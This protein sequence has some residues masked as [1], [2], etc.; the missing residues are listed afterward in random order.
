MIANLP[1]PAS[2]ESS[3][4]TL[5]LKHGEERRLAAGHLWVFSNEVDTDSTPLTAFSPG[6]PVQLQSDRDRFLGFAYVNPHSLICA[7]IVGRDPKYPLDKSLIVHR[8]KVALSLRRR[9]FSQPAYRL[10]YGESDGLPGLV[11]DRYG[12]VLVGQIGTAGMERLKPEIEAAL[13]K[14]VQPAG[15]LWKN[16]SSARELEQLP[17]YVEVGFGSVPETV[18]VVENGA[19]FTVPLAE[20][21][22]TGWFFDQA[23]NRRR[24]LDYIA[25]ARVLDVFS[26]LGAWGIA[27]AKHGS[28]EVSCVDASAQA[29]D[30]IERNAAANGLKLKTHKG[31]AF[32]VLESLIAAKEK[33]D[34]VVLDPPAFIKRKKDV[35]KGQAAYRRLNQLGMQLLGRDGMLVSCSCSYH[36]AE[37]DLL[38]AIQKAARHVGRF[39]Q[40]LEAGGQAPDHPVHPAI[41]ETK[42][43]KAFFCRA[44]QDT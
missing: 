2:A 17:R 14:V 23:A 43:L 4:P 13:S 27:A 24:F 38:D 36:L 18:E 44:L 12:D 11:I 10:V 39:V 20:G 15:L 7:R 5:R 19:R 30:W 34:V 6:D 33:F 26:Y 42:Y 31:D 22:K 41:P 8:L 37:S 32:E 16:D 3:L 1:G 29:I 21:Q 25:G 28:S 9:L 35:P 40:V